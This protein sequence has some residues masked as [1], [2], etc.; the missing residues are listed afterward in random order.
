MNHLIRITCLGALLL[1]VVAAVPASAQDLSFGYQYQRF[2]GG[3]DSLTAPA[4]FNLD[5]SVPVHRG[6]GIVGQFDTSRKNESDFQ[7]SGID[8]KETFATFGG[9][10]RWSGHANPAVTP[11]VQGLVGATRASASTDVAGVNVSDSDT[12]PMMQF[13]GGVAVPISHKVSAVGQVDYRRVFTED[14]G[15]NSV[16]AV[17]GVRIMLK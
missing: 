5:A 7:G 9:A 12:K 4:G 6:L 17:G 1:V 16:R 10:L 2:S 14:E 8:V 15:T 11:F 13:G 3:G